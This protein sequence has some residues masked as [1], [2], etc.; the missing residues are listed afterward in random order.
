MHV[1]VARELEQQAPLMGGQVYFCCDKS[2]YKIYK[3]FNTEFLG[4]QTLV[5][6]YPPIV[7]LLTTGDASYPQCPAAVA[8]PHTGAIHTPAESLHSGAMANTTFTVSTN[9]ALWHLGYK[10]LF[11]WE[12]INAYTIPWVQ[13]LEGSAW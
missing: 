5:H 3:N 8:A 10:S 7:A 9:K 11:S 2:P 13:A 12:E 1:L 4:L 6:R